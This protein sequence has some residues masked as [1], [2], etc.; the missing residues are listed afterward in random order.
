[1]NTMQ[2]TCPCGA[3][4]GGR[5]HTTR[6][7]NT[8]LEAADFEQ[9]IAD[10]VGRG[11]MQSSVMDRGSDSVQREVSALAVR[12]LRLVLHGLLMLRGVESM[13]LENV[14][15]GREL[16]SFV[17]EGSR[18]VARATNF[19]AEQYDHFLVWFRIL[20]ALHFYLSFHSCII[21][22]FL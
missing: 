7:D 10:G 4:I 17:F 6:D 19:L 22:S 11:Y 13:A 21:D 14:A 15:A 5:D 1:M 9:R 20:L 16:G 18:S 12:I 3:P 2:A 8:K